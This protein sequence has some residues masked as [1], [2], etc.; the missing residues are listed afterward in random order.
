MPNASPKAR[1]PNA[2][3]IP[4]TPLT[5]Q[6]KTLTLGVLPNVTAKCECLCVAVEYRLLCMYFVN[7][8]VCVYC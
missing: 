1:R 5:P 8:E 2:T 6:C 3:Y 4:L 7:N